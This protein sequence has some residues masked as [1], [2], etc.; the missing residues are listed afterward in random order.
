MTSPELSSVLSH[1]LGG[2][3]GGSE[4]N[5]LRERMQVQASRVSNLTSSR[6]ASRAQC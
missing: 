2:V 6:T 3:V 4:E 5:D 1:F